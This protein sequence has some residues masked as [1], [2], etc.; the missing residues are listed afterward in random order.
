MYQLKFTLKQHTPIIHFQHDQDGAT[1]RATE[2]KP[3]LDRFII[4]QCSLTEI[5][6]IDGKDKEV[7]KDEFKSW[8]IGEGKKHLALDYKMRINTTSERES[9]KEKILK[10][11]RNT[12]LPLFF[13]NMGDSYVGNEKS[14]HFI[15]KEIQNTIITNQN[16]LLKEVNNSLSAFFLSHNFGTRQSK[17]F[18]SFTIR[19]INEIEPEE[20]LS[21]FYKKSFSINISNLDYNEFKNTFLNLELFYKLIRSG[22]NQKKKLNTNDE[23]KSAISKQIL[24]IG[25]DKNNY[26]DICYIKSL[27]FLYFNSKNTNWEKKKIKIELFPTSKITLR[28]G[29]KLYF[30]YRLDEQQQSRNN[31]P[32]SPLHT[33]KDEFKLTKDLL[34]LA[35]EETWKSYNSKIEKIQAKKMYTSWIEVNKEDRTFIRFKS[36]ILI[37]PILNENNTKYTIH[38]I[39]NQKSINSALKVNKDFIIKDKFKSF[40]IEFP[41]SFSLI[42]YFDF[43]SDNSK[44]NLD[45]ITEDKFKNSNE[46]NVL[47]NIFNEFQKP[48]TP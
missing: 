12:S 13:G 10:N 24:H 17:G 16:D 46:Y 3:K 41:E 45:T 25:P 8:F 34:G 20:N 18:G 43:I 32:P 6:K 31:I 7:P 9:L 39:L 26:K 2:V 4:E 11:Q 22:L 40:K 33:D 42:D 28:D 36:P 27:L 23:I 21:I 30:P 15:S 44:I 47:K 37:K 35:A 5:K 29:R 48:A 38:F 14:I 19:K 1:L